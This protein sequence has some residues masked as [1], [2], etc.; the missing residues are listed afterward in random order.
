MLFCL[1]AKE[2]AYARVQPP[3]TPET[4]PGITTDQAPTLQML[5]SRIARHRLRQQLHILPGHCLF[6]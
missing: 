4:S 6:S 1:T 2:M 3:L 5:F